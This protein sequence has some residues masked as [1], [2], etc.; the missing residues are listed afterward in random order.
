MFLAQLSLFVNPPPPLPVPD[1]IYPLAE[2]ERNNYGQ[3]AAHYMERGSKLGQQLRPRYRCA[4]LYHKINILSKACLQV[5]QLS[6]K[7]QH[8][9]RAQ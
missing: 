3:L 5:C 2:R 1:W 7:Q 8:R 4:G 9:R 6:H